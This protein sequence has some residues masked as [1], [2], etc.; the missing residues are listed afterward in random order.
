LLHLP[1]LPCQVRPVPFLI[2]DYHDRICKAINASRLLGFKIV[3]DEFI[4][5]IP[6]FTKLM[7]I[8]PARRRGLCVLARI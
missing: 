5:P 6:S 1:S 7:Q 2:V 3:W 4:H 8:T